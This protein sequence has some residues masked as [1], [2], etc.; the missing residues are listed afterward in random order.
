V[1]RWLQ[2]KIEA[3]TILLRV[4]D[5][6]RITQGTIMSFGAT[7]SRRTSLPGVRLA[8]VESWCV[9]L[10]RDQRPMTASKRFHT[11]AAINPELDGI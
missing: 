2:E 5:L 1:F 6:R 8:Q 3:P 7:Q 11:V 10:Y 9:S 4:L